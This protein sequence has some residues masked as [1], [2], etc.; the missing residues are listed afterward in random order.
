MM[1]IESS[2]FEKNPIKPRQSL[3]DDRLI[4]IYVGIA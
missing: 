2:F 1:V 4:K 3:T